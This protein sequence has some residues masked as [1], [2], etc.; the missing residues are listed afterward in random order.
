MSPRNGTKRRQYF[1]NFLCDESVLT[2]F[3]FDLWEELYSSSFFTSAVQHRSLRQGASLA[4]ALGRPPG[5]FSYST[6]AD[7]ILCFMQVSK[8]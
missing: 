4:T 6:Q 3:R 2:L 7:N 8:H 1:L 5:V